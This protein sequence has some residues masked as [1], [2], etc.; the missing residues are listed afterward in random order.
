VTI[1]DD[2][3]PAPAPPDRDADG[4]PDA[5]DNCP[6]V[7]NGDQADKI[8]GGTGVNVVKA[9]AGNDTIKA[10]NKKRETI[11]CGAGKDTVTADKT[12]ML[13]GCETKKR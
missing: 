9:G 7:A 3:T 6:N 12:D 11:D 13:K 1:V 8:D 5:S 10:K 4:V 2:D